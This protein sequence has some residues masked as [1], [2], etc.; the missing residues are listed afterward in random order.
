MQSL[1]VAT[2]AAAE[3]DEAG[4][5]ASADSCARAMLEGL[6]QVM[7]FIRREMRRHRTHRL[8]VPQYRTL[9]V[10]DRFPT[11]S[12]SQ[13]AERLGGSLPTV[14]RMV[15]GLVSKGLVVRKACEGDRRRMALV[16]TPK[17]RRAYEGAQLETQQTVAAQIEHLTD[18][19]RATVSEAMKLLHGVFANALSN[20]VGFDSDE[21]EESLNHGDTETRREQKK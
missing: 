5:D 20:S 2:I 21:D 14:S 4:T 17:G 15:A 18:A 11:A 3:P 7:W 8:S 16:L 1:S 19:D 13:V 10:L 9:V 6:P 12:L